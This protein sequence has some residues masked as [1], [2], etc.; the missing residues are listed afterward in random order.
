MEMLSSLF[1]NLGKADT[2]NLSFDYIAKDS[3]ELVSEPKTVTLSIAGSNDALII[4]DVVVG[5]IIKSDFDS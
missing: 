1:N 5:H 3:T 2:I 4:Q